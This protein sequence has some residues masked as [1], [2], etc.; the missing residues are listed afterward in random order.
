MSLGGKSAGDLS[1][2]WPSQITAATGRGG[3]GSI[4]QIQSRDQL[5][6]GS[7]AHSGDRDFV[8]WWVKSGYPTRE[9]A[10]LGPVTST[11]APQSIADIKPRLPVTQ[12]PVKAPPAGSGIIEQTEN[13]MSLLADIG[14]GLANI[15]LTRV[16]Q[17][18]GVL[19]GGAPA[20]A[21]ILP[22]LGPIVTGA[23]RVL[24]SP[25]GRRAAGTVV[26]TAAGV[27]GGNLMTGGGVDPGQ[28]GNGC[29]S[30]FHP[31]KETRT[32]CVRNRRMNYG[33]GTAA[34][35]AIRRIKGTRRMLQDI[36]RSLPKRT[37]RTRARSGSHSHS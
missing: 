7:S 31:D 36:E 18:A 4:Q 37:V 2:M 24:T 27:A 25:A 6:E 35:R 5:R 34:R 28:P 21:N 17:R 12:T 29:A 19:P 3:Y 30:G 8:P 13:E 15:G 22:A 20:Q 33:N 11:P 32:R 26:A 23:G 16:A 10:V 14:R 1:R 9:A